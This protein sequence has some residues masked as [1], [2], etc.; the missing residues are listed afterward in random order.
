MCAALATRGTPGDGGGPGLM[1]LT[2]KVESSD[3]Q[4]FTARA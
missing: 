4:G 1:A 2:Q 3:P